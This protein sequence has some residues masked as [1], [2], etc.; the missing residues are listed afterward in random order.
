MQ[1]DVLWWTMTVQSWLRSCMAS[2][3]AFLPAYQHIWFFERQ[4][5]SSLY[6]EP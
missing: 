4:C 2:V 5:W 3:L 6:P 1:D